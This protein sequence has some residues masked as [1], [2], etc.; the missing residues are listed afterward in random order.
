[1]LYLKPDD[2]LYVL[3][4]I[5]YW[6]HAQGSAG[7]SESG[8]LIEKNELLQKLCKEIQILKKC[9][10]HQAKAE[11]DR[12]VGFIQRRT[13][14]LNE[15]GR[16]CYAFVHKTFQEYLTAE[17]IYDLADCGDDTTI[18]LNH[19]REHLH[20]QH[21]R[22]VLLLLVSKLRGRK[23]EKALNAVLDVN[24][25]Y[26]QWLHRDLLFVGWCL[27]ENPPEL[28]TVASDLTQ[29]ILVKLVKI[30]ICGVGNSSEHVRRN[31][32]EILQRLGGTSFEGDAWECLS[33]YVSKISRSRMLNFQSSLGGEKKV[34]EYLFDLLDNQ[35]ADQKYVAVVELGRL[36]NSST[37]VLDCLLGLL[38]N[39]DS[40]IRYL[41]A[42][43][44]GQLGDNSF[45][46]LNG[47]IKLLKDSDADVCAS[48]I[49][50]LGQLGGDSEVVLSALIN[51]LDGDSIV[52]SSAVSAL[53]YLRGSS[54]I[55]LRKLLHLLENDE[56]GEVRF[57]IIATLG[58]LGNTSDVV[59]N[60][61]LSLLQNTSP[62]IRFGVAATLGQL[63]NTSDA[64]LDGLL[65]LLKDHN[66]DVRVTG[67]VALGQL[68]DQSERV[69]SG[70][71]NLLRDHDS[72]VQYSAAAALVRLG[73]SSED[74]SRTLFDLLKV[75]TLMIRSRAAALLIELDDAPLELLDELLN[76]LETDNLNVRYSVTR[77][78]VK[79]SKMSN[80]VLPSLVKWIEQ[81]PKNVLVDSAIDALWSIVVE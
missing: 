34:V 50:A 30:E 75:T 3:K 40:K 13:G 53:G 46:V 57:R 28:R 42:K 24:S 33:P 8:T 35:D 48:A 18:I 68:N 2:L 78:L 71:L 36:G 25:E 5:C 47:L 38:Q 66:A 55:V 17:E 27:S 76:L 31:V 44:L 56:S 23:A 74:L 70:L 11:A 72:S 22:E 4:K 81:Q 59:L 6:I 65:G 9:E 19:F 29:K 21:W 39:H 12:F 54:E 58:Q 49:S 51:A 7:E 14:L 20:D 52:R 1:L 45:S 61:L 77:S 60:G 73:H 43:S 32:A 69:E 67:A 62:S 79:L 16:E 63:G 80:D 10:P 26:E 37:S 41:A 64:V 15:Q